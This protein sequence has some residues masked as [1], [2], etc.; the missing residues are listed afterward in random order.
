MTRR[1]IPPS[2][3]V[4][5]FQRAEGRCHICGEKIDAGRESYDIEHVIPLGLGGTEGKMD[6][7]LQPAHTSCHKGKTA[8]DKGQI[9]KSKRMRQRSMGITRQ[10]A[11]PLPGGRKSKWKRKIDGTVVPR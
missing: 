2:E 1:R 9:A 10:S 11:S 4:L 8:E 5:I 7:N 6:E 3:R